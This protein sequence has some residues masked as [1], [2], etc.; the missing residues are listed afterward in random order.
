MWD[1]GG[2]WTRL[3]SPASFLGANIFEGKA[4]EILA[5]GDQ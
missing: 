1:R 2:D 3:E 4:A 5:Q